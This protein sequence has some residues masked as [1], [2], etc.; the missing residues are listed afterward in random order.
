[1]KGE[2]PKNRE[3][4]LH[5]VIL[6]DWLE[7]EHRA[8]IVIDSAQTIVWINA[9]ARRHLDD[10]SCLTPKDER[11]AFTS[12]H[13]QRRFESY[14]ATLGST[15]STIAIRLADGKSHFLFRGCRLE[16]GAGSFACLEF[17]RDTPFHPSRYL[18]FDSVF[19]LTRAEHRVALNLL[20][21]QSAHQI[22]ECSDVSIET[23][24]S[25]I[26]AL[27]AKMGV[28]RREELFFRLAPYCVT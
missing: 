7:K 8:R 5:H 20:D 27:Y 17:A 15:L 21:G 19:Q 24:R 9:A 14:L 11:F 18:D 12:P 23:V 3:K 26:R 4:P 25:Q 28:S 1:M 10:S 22:A 6:H 2:N 13:E 16:S